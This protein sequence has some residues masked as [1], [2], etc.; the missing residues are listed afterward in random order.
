MTDPCNQ[1]M[2]SISSAPLLEKITLILFRNKCKICYP[3]QNSTDIIKLMD[4]ANQNR[5]HGK[6]STYVV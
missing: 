3:F 4:G 2:K 5:G 6:I 1:K